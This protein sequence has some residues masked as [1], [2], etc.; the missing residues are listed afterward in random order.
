MINIVTCLIICL[1]VLLVFLRFFWM[2]NVIITMFFSL[3]ML[4][5]HAIIMIGFEMCAHEAEAAKGAVKKLS[6]N[7][8]AWFVW[9]FS[10]MKPL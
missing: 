6:R 4:Q 10:V 3:T 9:I 7:C 2:K 1:F 5:M 8:F